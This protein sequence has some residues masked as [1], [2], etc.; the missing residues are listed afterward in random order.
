MFTCPHT[1][2]NLGPK[3]F[4]WST[5]FVAFQSIDEEYIILLTRR[6]INALKWC[7]NLLWEK[8]SRSCV[9]KL[10]VVKTWVVLRSLEENNTGAKGSIY[11]QFLMIWCDMWTYEHDLNIPTE[12]GWSLPLVC[13]RSSVVTQ[14][15]TSSWNCWR[16]QQLSGFQKI[17]L[18]YQKFLI[19]QSLSVQ[20]QRPLKRS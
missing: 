17:L 8:L 3:T 19:Q 18:K 11:F 7:W 10:K 6:V 4:D 20:W 9:W 14:F 2:V 16:V 12:F 1:S 5:S 13:V 15:K